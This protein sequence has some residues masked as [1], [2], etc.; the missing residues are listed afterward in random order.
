[1]DYLHQ[2]QSVFFYSGKDWTSKDFS[3][4]H[5]YELLFAQYCS[6]FEVRF[7]LFVLAKL[8]GTTN[9]SQTAELLLL[10]IFL[11]VAQ[12]HGHTH[13]LEYHHLPVC[14]ASCAEGSTT[15]KQTPHTTTKNWFQVSKAELSTEDYLHKAATHELVSCLIDLPFLTVQAGHSLLFATP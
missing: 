7:V 5:G 15:D 13:T 8:S 6:I 4:C 12:R 2:S 10:H 14:H 11:T 9:P 3:E 1:M